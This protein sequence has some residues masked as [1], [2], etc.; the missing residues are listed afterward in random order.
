MT[1]QIG[2]RRP[3]RPLGIACAVTFAAAMLGGCASRVAVGA[4]PS[5]SFDMPMTPP[6]VSLTKQRVPVVKADSSARR[7]DPLAEWAAQLARTTG[8]PSRALQAYGRT[9]L[10]MRKRMPACRLSWVLL[11]GIGRVESDHG[12]FGGAVLDARGRVTEPIIGVPLDG[13][14]AVARVLDTDRGALDGDRIYDRAVGPMQ[15]L[16]S[17]WKHYGSDGN[18]DGASDPQQID[19]AALAAG[20]YLC[21]GGRD[22][23]TSDGW[24]TGVLSYNRSTAYGRQVLQWANTYARLSRSV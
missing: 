23:S 1:A 14:P 5:D 11:A 15:F 24:W 7:V 18:R 12:R 17:T 16:P 9:E 20:R 10:T 21:V 3:L 2:R 8:V 22:L 4:M 19:D 13:S 6:A